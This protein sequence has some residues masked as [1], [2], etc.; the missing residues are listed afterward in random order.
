MHSL[1]D[2]VTRAIG[3]F[4]FGE[5]IT[6]DDNIKLGIL[7]IINLISDYHEE[8]IA[9]Y[10]EILITTN[11]EALQ[12]IPNKQL[13]IKDT[14][15]SVAAFKKA[16]KLCAPLATNSWTILVEVKDNR[17]K[18][19]IIN[20]ELSETTPSLYNQMFG[21][22]KIDL[23]KDKVIYIRNIG[24]KTV[25]LSG[26][27][28]TVN[29]SL[30]LDHPRTTSSNEILELSLAATSSCD[31]VLKNKIQTFFEKTITEGL[32]IGHGNLVA[33]VKDDISCIEK[34]KIAQPDGEY[35]S[36]PIDFQSLIT[37]VENINN[38]ESTTHL[39]N[40]SSLF[41][42][43]LN[44]DG[45]TVLSDTGKIIGYHIFIK[46]EHVAEESG[47]ARSRA[48]S[49]MKNCK[50]FVFSFFKSQDGNIKIGKEN[51]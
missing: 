20:C 50:L 1:R 15:L 48:F 21:A 32:R 46:N 22:T 45:I 16:I 28:D 12:S 23:Q 47:G 11:L 40:Y 29:V 27:K 42:A 26:L 3:N 17:I 7:E 35:L 13:I 14:E 44:H 18:Y 34:L 5:G 10:P 4:L 24:Q 25:E 38:T 33:I 6:G 49:A 2:D 30:T 36:V 39:K 8:G 19:G 51:E 9:L 43:M 41:K 37:E 31:P